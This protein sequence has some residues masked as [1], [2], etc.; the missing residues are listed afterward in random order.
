M[1]NLAFGLEVMLIGFAGV[2]VALSA[3]YV[4]MVLLEKFFAKKNNKAKAPQP[5]TT[6]DG[7]SLAPPKPEA[8]DGP[9]DELA[10][11]IAAALSVYTKKPLASLAIKGITP[12]GQTNSWVHYGRTRNMDLKSSVNAKRREKRI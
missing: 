4:L 12:V 9:A 3:L 2:F 11:V 10:A 7:I 8:E 6:G 5:E 1:E